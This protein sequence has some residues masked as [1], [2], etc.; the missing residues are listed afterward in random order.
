MLSSENEID[1]SKIYLNAHGTST[2]LNDKT[3]T[4]AIKQAFGDEKARMLHISSTKS[5][6]GHMLGAAGAVE[7]IASVLALRSGIVPPTINYLEPDE[8]C[9]LNYTPNKAVKADI[10]LALSTSFGFG[11][12]NACVAFK[13]I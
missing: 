6:T 3:E 12:H 7:A 5:M 11:G 10:E 4:A 8:E 9:D 1:A 2:S 13:K